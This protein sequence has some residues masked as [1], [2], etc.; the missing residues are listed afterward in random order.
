MRTGIQSIRD[1]ARAHGL[2]FRDL[3]R[4]ETLSGAHDLAWQE[5]APVVGHVREFY[6]A[7]VASAVPGLSGAFT[8]EEGRVVAAYFV[9]KKSG[10]AVSAI[11]DGALAS[12]SITFPRRQ[13]LIL[14]G[15]ALVVDREWRGRGLGAALRDLPRALGADMVIGQ[16][17]KVLDN[18]DEWMG[19]RKL[20][21][22]YPGSWFTAASYAHDLTIRGIA[23]CASPAPGARNS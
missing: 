5:F 6:D 21:A 2:E 20:V 14:E 12:G 1:H 11:L 4:P 22:E 9:G 15:L 19:V 23:P 13:V 7:E 16:Q 18:L 17:A 10:R 3:S 8:T